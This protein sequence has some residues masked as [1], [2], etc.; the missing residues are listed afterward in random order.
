LR[1]RQRQRREG[2]GGTPTRCDLARGD[3]LALRLLHGGRCAREEA[4]RR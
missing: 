4:G 3:A 2:G 1:Q